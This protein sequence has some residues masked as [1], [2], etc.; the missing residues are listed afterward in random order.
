MLIANEMQF[1]INLPAAGDSLVNTHHRDRHYLVEN[2]QEKKQ[3]I[4][5]LKIN[6]MRL[7]EVNKLVHRKKVRQKKGIE[8]VRQKSASFHLG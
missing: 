3:T 5:R 1:L 6:L 8:K 2:G 7:I 4:I